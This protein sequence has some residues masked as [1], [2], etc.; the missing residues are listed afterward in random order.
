MNLKFQLA[1]T[2]TKVLTLV[3]LLL[4]ITFLQCKKSSTEDLE[5]LSPVA[6]QLRVNEWLSTQKNNTQNLVKIDKINSL[7]SVL[8]FNEL[9]TEDI[10]QQEK[11]I[12]VPLKKDYK[13]SYNSNKQLGS[14]L[15]LILNKNNEIRKGEIV[16]YQLPNNEITEKIPD[17]LLKK[18]YS[19][20]EWNGKLYFLNLTGTI[21]YEV[22]NR[23]N[24][25]YSFG[26]I[27]TKETINQRSN[28][29]ID[30][31]LV[32]TIYWP[33]G[34]TDTIDQYVGTTCGG[35]PSEN[36]EFQPELNSG[37]EVGTD[38]TH[39]ESW[40][41][42]TYDLGAWSVRSKETFYGKSYSNA[43]SHF[44]T[45]N[46]DESKIICS[47]NYAFWTEILF[48]TTYGPGKYNVS[49]WVK[50]TVTYGDPARL[51]YSVSNHSIWLAPSL[52]P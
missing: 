34:T 13:S 42:D 22:E 30:W 37:G 50:G 9:K 39:T 38:V 19:Q 33:D 5:S 44:T 10:Q 16:Q 43:W 7:L 31:Y 23:N 17:E 20:Q 8:Q 12:I 40:L 4:S 47:P 11:I 35:G 41:V 52:W 45:V 51:P 24:K 18:F 29:C 3:L 49:T 46:H 15:L 25:V 2:N 21:K 1:K 48:N 14:C 6:L 32:T 36:Q 28:S 26:T 27:K